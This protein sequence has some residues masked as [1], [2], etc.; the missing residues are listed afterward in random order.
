[1]HWRRFKGVEEGRF[2]VM[3]LPHS[4]AFFV[5][6]FERECTESYWEG[7]VRAFESFGGRSEPGSVT[8]IAKY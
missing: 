5:M 1:M 8:T 7:H 6:A 3:A 2:F 4:D